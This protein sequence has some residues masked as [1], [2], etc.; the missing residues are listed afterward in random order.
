MTPEGG[1]AR[2]RHRAER[3]GEPR[4]G[5]TAEASRSLKRRKEW[6][7]PGQEG[8]R[9]SHCVH[10]GGQFAAGLACPPSPGR[11][12][13][14]SLSS[15]A[16]MACHIATPS[17]SPARASSPIRPATWSG[18]WSPKRFSTA[19]AQAQRCCSSVMRGHHRH[20]TTI[21]PMA[22]GRMSYTRSGHIIRN[23]CRRRRGPDASHSPANPGVPVLLRR[24]GL[25]RSWETRHYRT[26]VAAML[27]LEHSGPSRHDNAGHRSCDRYGI[28]R[29]R[30]F[31]DG[32][33]PSRPQRP[34]EIQRLATCG[35]SSTSPGNRMPCMAA[36]RQL[37]CSDAFPNIGSSAQRNHR[38]P[39][40][41]RGRPSAA[42]CRR[43][44]YGCPLPRLSRRSAWPVP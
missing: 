37:S 39:S 36:P 42:M 16:A 19:S 10:I 4:T 11:P 7:G 40:R 5:L 41:M 17:A 22:V 30:F 31:R 9:C 18:A 26:A 15:R 23:R 24:R 8:D 25:Q 1:A 33:A 38:V 28:R 6:R 3:E 32:Q 44:R 21:C 35:N 2:R 43:P 27:Q 14:R 29:R 34:V 12:L 13:C 20:K